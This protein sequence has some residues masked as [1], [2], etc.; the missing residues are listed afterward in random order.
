MSTESTTLTTTLTTEQRFLAA[1]AQIRERGVDFTLNVS[2][3]WTYSGQWLVVGPAN[4]IQSLP[5]PHAWTLSGQD[6]RPKVTWPSQDRHLGFDEHG[7]PFF[8]EN[9]DEV[10]RKNLCT[11]A[12]FEVDDK[13]GVEDGTCVPHSDGPYLPQR[14]P[15]RSLVIHHGGQGTVAANVVTDAF[16]DHGFTVQWNGSNVSDI[17]VRL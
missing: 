10:R 1:V 3:T 7:T 11:C 15:A 9:D 12:L 6:R 8:V 16:R 14:L 5:A 13:G 2:D 4:L 17:Q